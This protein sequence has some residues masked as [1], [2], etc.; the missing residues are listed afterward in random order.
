MSSYNSAT[1]PNHQSAG[2]PT[3]CETCHNTTQWQ[4]A[5]FNHSNTRFPLTGKHTAAQCAQC[6]VGG[7]Y[8]GL[9]TDCATCHLAAY[10]GTTNPNHQSAG[11]P[12]D[13]SLCHNTSQW[14]GATFNHSATQFPLTGKHTTVQC[15][16]CHVGGKYAGLGTACATCHLAAYNGTTNPNHQAAGFPTSCEICHNTTQWPGA[17]FNHSTTRFPLTG[18]H[19]T[20]QCAQCHVSGVYR[21]TPTDCYSCH[22]TVYSTVTN[23]NHVAA[24][25][26]TTCQT[27]HNTTQ[28]SGARFDHTGFPIYSG[29]HAG[30]WQTCNDCHSN[31][32]DYAAFT[33]TNCHEHAKTTM[34]SKHREVRSY[35]YNSLNCYSCHPNG[36]H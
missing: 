26:P 16:Q 25:F 29:S 20:V 21:G 9:G 22:K 32:S 14:A 17:T 27:C 12:Q 36:R 35:V 1:N 2:F 13:C 19:T 34:D 23:P 28:W 18:K 33:C 11:F 6:H 15:A 24:G 3:T 30:K 31:P 7:K 5:T 8:A 10:N 4:G